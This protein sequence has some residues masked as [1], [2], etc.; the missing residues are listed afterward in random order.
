MRHP[1][2]ARRLDLGVA[3]VH[4][5]SALGAGKPKKRKPRRLRLSFAHPIHGRLEIQMR[6]G[7][8]VRTCRWPMPLAASDASDAPRWIQVAR[9]GEFRGHPVIVQGTGASQKLETGE[10]LWQVSEDL[11]GVTFPAILKSGMANAAG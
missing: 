8:E 6:D 11:T 5:P 10:R 9:C 3:D 1:V 7:E 4:Q 2:S